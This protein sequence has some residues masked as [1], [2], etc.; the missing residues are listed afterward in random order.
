VRR[1]TVVVLALY[2]LLVVGIITLA[3]VGG[4]EQVFAV[5]RLVPYGDK[6]GHFVLI[7]LLALL[8]DLALGRRDVTVGT[9]KVPLGP[10]IVSVLVVLEELSQIALPTRS[11]DLL[12]LTADALGIALFVAI[13]RRVALRHAAIA[14]S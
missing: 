12:D 7:G 2:V 6:L 3:N 8:A 9:M 4:T 5:V 10:A 14:G 1:W 13:G 11:F